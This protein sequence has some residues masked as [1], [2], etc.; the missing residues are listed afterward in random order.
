MSIDMPRFSRGYDVHYKS[1]PAEGTD[2]TSEEV[3][4]HV[5]RSGEAVRWLR[6]HVRA[7]ARELGG[8]ELDTIMVWL[9]DA[10]EYHQVV[11][12]LGRSK[13][14]IL[15]LKTDRWVVLLNAEPSD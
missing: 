4:A 14:F 9:N 7:T 8:E 11:K 1:T 13:S 3:S 5:D 6:R 2:V 10:R 15:S 12:D